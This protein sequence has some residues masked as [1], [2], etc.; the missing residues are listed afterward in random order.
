MNKIN[1]LKRILKNHLGSLL[2]AVLIAETAYMGYLIYEQKTQPNYLMQIPID[3]WFMLTTQQQ[4]ALIDSLF[5]Y[6]KSKDQ[7]FDSK[8]TIV[9]FYEDK[10]NNMFKVLFVNGRVESRPLKT[11]TPPKVSSDV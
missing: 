4:D 2:I 7:G 3:S 5:A 9:Y 6:A 10:N 11:P 1:F 8:N